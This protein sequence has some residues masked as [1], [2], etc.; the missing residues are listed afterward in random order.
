MWMQN[1]SNQT[2][3]YSHFYEKCSARGMFFQ[4]MSSVH[5]EIKWAKHTPYNTPYAVH[6]MACRK[7]TNVCC[8]TYPSLPVTNEDTLPDHAVVILVEVLLGRDVVVSDCLFGVTVSIRL[9]FQE[10]LLTKHMITH[11]VFAIY[12][13][14]SS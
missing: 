1:H 3:F 12:L 8:C 13:K 2:P 11:C 6:H 4:H 5:L 14:M 10:K 7:L 9:T